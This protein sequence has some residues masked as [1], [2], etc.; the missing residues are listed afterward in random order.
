M[1][2]ILETADVFVLDVVDVVDRPAGVE[3]RGELPPG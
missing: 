2:S 1:D 3:Y